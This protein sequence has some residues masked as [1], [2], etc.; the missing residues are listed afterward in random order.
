MLRR[1]NSKK[2]T[3]KNK[4]AD[5]LKSYKIFFEKI[6]HSPSTIKIIRKK[7]KDLWLKKAK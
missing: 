5:D 7:D 2:K 3:I 6:D 4:P 1:T